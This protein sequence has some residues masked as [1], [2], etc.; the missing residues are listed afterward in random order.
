MIFNLLKLALFSLWPFANFYYVNI[1]Q[2][3]KVLT[4]G[5]YFLVFYFLVLAVYGLLLLLSRK[6][7][8]PRRLSD[9]VSLGIVLFFSFDLFYHHTAHAS[10]Y[11][12]IALGALCSAAWIFSKKEEFSK[13]L[14]TVAL[15]MA[16][17]PFLQAGLYKLSTGQSAP[18]LSNH[19][20]ATFKPSRF[21]SV[22]TGQPLEEIEVDHLVRTPNIYYVILDEY[23]RADDILAQTRLDNSGFIRDI[24]TRG[25]YTASKSYSNFPITAFSVSSSLQMDYL[26]EP[27]DHAFKD[28]GP[29]YEALQGSNRIVDF[30]KKHGYE[31]LHFENGLWEGSNC[32]GSEDFCIHRTRIEM[33]EMSKKLL[34]LTPLLQVWNRWIL[35]HFQSEILGQSGLL[36]LLAWRDSR[37]YDGRPYFVFAHI[38]SP[39]EPVYYAEDCSILKQPDESTNRPGYRNQVACL[40]HEVLDFI[41][42]VIAK[43][44]GAIM[45]FQGDHGTDFQDQFNT[46]LKEWTPAQVEERM[47]IFNT[48]RL[49]KDCQNLLYPSISPVNSLRVVVA[50]LGGT[51]PKLLPD[52]K[53][54]V[55]YENRPDYGSVVE[56]K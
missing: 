24:A 55:T 44:P 12:V 5:K 14:F 34:S 36:K 7:L 33:T 48:Y 11:W 6:R 19:E 51:V 3:P 15:V 30:L 27:G 13:V 47:A 29:F 32:S 2:V 31:Y 46:N 56:A 52:R 21:N 49:P 53:F 28:R 23:A 18:R 17:L 22:T 4:L 16:V 50:C 26:V 41:D 20:S 37:K 42:K 40:N 54:L 38:F 45:I 43:D 10:L 9:G 8:D 39:H 25:F 35:P 1:R